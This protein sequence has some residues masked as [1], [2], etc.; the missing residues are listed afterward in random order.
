MTLQ[1]QRAQIAQPGGST[2]DENDLLADEH[3]HEEDSTPA[4]TRQ[5]APADD[6]ALTGE[7][8]PEKYR[9]KSARDLLDIIRQQEEF[10]GRQSNELGQLREQVG[11]LRGVVDKAIA[12][13]AG[14]QPSRNEDEHAELTADDLLNNPTE[15]IN[16]AV[17]SALE[18]VTRRFED[19]SYK[20]QQQDFLSRHETAT[21]DVNDPNFV[22]Y[23]KQSP[24]RKRLAEKAFAD[25]NRI[26][27]E[28]AEELWLGYDEVRAS[29]S[30]ST[31]TE[32]DLNSAGD[33]VPAKPKP[34][35][36]EVALVRSGGSDGEPSGD[37]KI[38]SRSKLVKLQA[39]DPDTYYDPAFQAKVAAA[40]REGRVR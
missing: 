25:P 9:G 5:Q 21:Q 37:S 36:S 2:P 7:E 33:S 14:E 39:E 16:R 13:Q 32:Q 1:A 27:F 12:L 22:D 11:T 18:P 4:S 17:T 3:G 20:E 15:A 28:A 30:A 24:Y 29:E 8:V 6:E 10:T 31:E 35:P 34:S 26:D 19:M 40:Y 23:V 38:Y